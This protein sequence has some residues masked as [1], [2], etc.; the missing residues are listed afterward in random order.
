MGPLHLAGERPSFFSTMRLEWKSLGNQDITSHYP[1]NLLTL[2]LPASRSVREKF[3]FTSHLVYYK[4]QSILNKDSQYVATGKQG[5]DESSPKPNWKW[6]RQNA[7]Y[8]PL[9]HFCLQLRGVTTV[10]QWD[11][12]LP[13]IL[14]PPGQKVTKT[15]RL[16]SHTCT[17]SS[18][19]QSLSISSSYSHAL[20]TS[21]CVMGTSRL[22][23]LTWLWLSACLLSHII[24]PLMSRVKSSL[25][26]RDL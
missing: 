26:V 4:F 6:D 10:Y 24:L 19:P 20:A 21:A 2:G 22:S 13:S 17:V 18:L 15:A 11:S 16:L 14:L 3:L 5:R 25:W 7:R 8:P 12:S 1:D 9:P 23:K